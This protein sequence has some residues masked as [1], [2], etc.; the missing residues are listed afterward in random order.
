MTPEQ[1]HRAAAKRHPGMVLHSPRGSG[2]ESAQRAGAST[3]RAFV[4]F[5]HERLRE[6]IAAAT[7]RRRTAVGEQADIVDRGLGLLNELISDIDHGRK[8]DQ[9][10]VRLLTLAYRKHPQF[11]REWVT[12]AGPSSG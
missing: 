3:Y 10:S 11:R 8:L 4:A 7:S 6:E 5:L 2:R 1:I 12:V 9:T